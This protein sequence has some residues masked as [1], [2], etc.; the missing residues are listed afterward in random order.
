MKLA[1]R[2]PPGAKIKEQESP[3]A[4]HPGLS[5]PGHNCTP[6]SF[7]TTS[8]AS[9][10]RAMALE[11]LVHLLVKEAWLLCHR[12]MHLLRVLWTIKSRSRWKALHSHMAV[13]GGLERGH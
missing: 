12:L 10:V 13:L 5:Q 11:S 3:S 1:P 9:R 7:P 4:D 2:A 8:Y 6:T